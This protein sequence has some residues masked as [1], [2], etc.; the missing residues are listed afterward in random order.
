MSHWCSCDEAEARRADIGGPRKGPG[1]ASR[2][3]KVVVVGW[4]GH[5]HLCDAREDGSKGKC[6]EMVGR[7]FGGGTRKSVLLFGPDRGAVDW[8]VIK[9]KFF[10]IVSHG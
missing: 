1:R 7:E 2:G 3:W 6:C 4:M 8:W 10:F 9:K 5:H